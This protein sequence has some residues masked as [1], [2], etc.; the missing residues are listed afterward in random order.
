[1]NRRKQRKQRI[2]GNQTWTASPARVESAG[3]NFSDKL[4]NLCSL[5]FLSP[6]RGLYEPECLFK[7]ISVFRINRK[8]A[9][10]RQTD[11]EVKSCKTG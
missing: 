2:N 1:M 9:G 8:V 5:R 4:L 7:F 6:S 3:G 11:K 10:F